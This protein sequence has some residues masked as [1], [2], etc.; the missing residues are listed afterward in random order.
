MRHCYEELIQVS[1]LQPNLCHANN[2]PVGSA[3]ALQMCR[4]QALPGPDDG[5]SGTVLVRVQVRMP[6]PKSPTHSLGPLARSTLGLSDQEG[7]PIMV[8]ELVSVSWLGPRQARPGTLPGMLCSTFIQLL[9][10]IISS[11]AQTTTLIGV[12]NETLQPSR[13][14]KHPSLQRHRGFPNSTMGSTALAFGRFV[15]RGAALLRPST[16][17]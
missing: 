10:A 4:R 8:C 2:S 5:L 3:R 13:H 1:R 17:V 14:F 11:A 16:G 15:S 9:S 7:G 6:Y 12:N